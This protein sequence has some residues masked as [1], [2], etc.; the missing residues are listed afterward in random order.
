MVTINLTIFIQLGLFLLFVWLAN[1][2][3]F[4][5]VLRLMDER[6]NTVEADESAARGDRAKANELHARYL[7]DLAAARRAASARYEA[8][9]R[10]AQDKR[11]RALAARRAEADQEVAGLSRQLRE[12]IKGERA[13]YDECV[14]PIAGAIRD[15]LRIGGG[16]A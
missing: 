9:L 5:P 16:R 15:R 14:G 8:A 4:R 7:A 13:R 12:Q 10:T 3:V 2:L 1:A 6:E 11:S